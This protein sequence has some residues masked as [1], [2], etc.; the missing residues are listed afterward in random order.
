MDAAVLGTS[1]LAV[2][3]EVVGGF[4]GAVGGIVISATSSW[5]P[6]VVAA[7][8]AVLRF[9]VIPEPTPVENAR[10]VAAL[11][12]RGLR[13]GTRRVGRWVRVAWVPLLLALPV[14]FYTLVPVRWSQ[15]WRPMP[16]SGDEPH[17]LIVVD[18][19]VRDHSLN[20]FPAYARDREERRIVGPIDWRNHSRGENDRWFSL[21]GIGLPVLVAPV[22]LLFG[23]T[24][25]RLMLAA[26]AGLIPV[27]VYRAARLA[28]IRPGESVGLALCVSL[29]LPF[30]AVSG[31]IYPDLLSGILVLALAVM[32]WR[33]WCRGAPPGAWMAG[34]LML[35]ILPWLHLKNVLV[36]A[37]LAIALTVAWWR[38]D[39]RRTGWC[40]WFVGLN[41]ASVL[42]LLTYHLVA[43]G[44]PLGPYT[45]GRGADATLYQAGM[46]FLGLHFDQ[47]QGVFVQQPLYL[48]GLVGLPLLFRRAPFIAVTATAA[49]LAI[50]VP[51]TFHSCWYGCF[52]MSG[53]FMWGAAALWSFPLLV[54]YADLGAVGRRVLWVAGGL[55]LGWQVMLARDWYTAPGRFFTTWTSYS[56]NSLFTQAWHGVLPSFYDFDRYLTFPPNIAA[57]VIASALLAVGVALARRTPVLDDGSAAGCGDAGGSALVECK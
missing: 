13:R 47:A 36:V 39:R 48:L 51:N 5:R 37:V 14:V 6:A 16:L 4:R 30:L 27:F 25:V 7:A 43:F 23:P 22:F 56:R 8:L 54:L 38:G 49:Y 44:G 46:I 33:I 42:L 24:G 41:A 12:A 53:R 35:A 11:M 26:I 20:V 50:V 40:W 19:L 45:T 9:L 1:T 31:Q 57:F 21:H 18:A 2:V 10:A 29:G 34:A 17:Y 32:A 52:S 3:I 28:R 55:G 15:A